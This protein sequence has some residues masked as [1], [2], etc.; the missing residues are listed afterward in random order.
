MKRLVSFAAKAALLLLIWAGEP[1]NAAEKW[2]GLDETVV[3]KIA[4]EH[5]REA[6][7]ALIDTGEGDLQL[8][9]FLVAGAIGGFVAGYCWRALLDGKGKR[10]NEGDRT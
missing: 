1:L 3:Q 2:Q 4:R 5:G 8:F 7:K 9:A 10:G 6:K